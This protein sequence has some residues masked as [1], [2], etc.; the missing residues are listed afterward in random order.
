MTGNESGSCPPHDAMGANAIN[1][2]AE[3]L[4]PRIEEV[5]GGR[6]TFRGEDLLEQEP[7]ERARAG[8]FLAFQY[9]VEIPGVGVLTNPVKGDHR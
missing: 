3:A 4:A 6:V 2:T 9:P 8:V 7:D 1:T 5:T